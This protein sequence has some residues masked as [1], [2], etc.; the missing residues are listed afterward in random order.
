MTPQELKAPGED[1]KTNGMKVS[2]V[3]LQQRWDWRLLDGRNRL[4]AMVDSYRPKR[5]RTDVDPYA[6]A[7]S[8]RAE[9]V[10]A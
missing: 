8:T 2:I 9:A 6:F 4:D 10:G 7:A 1:I 3:I 5:R